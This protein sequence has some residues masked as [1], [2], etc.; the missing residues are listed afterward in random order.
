MARTIK[1]AHEGALFTLMVDKT[2]NIISGGRD[3]KIVQWD[4]GL[5][6]TGNVLEVSG[7]G[8]GGMLSEGSVCGKR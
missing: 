5:S 8:G 3:G 1:G 7:S 6:R 2:G 4:R